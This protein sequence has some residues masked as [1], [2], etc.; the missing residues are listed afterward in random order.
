M[1]VE[2]KAAGPSSS[3][4]DA[5]ATRIPPRLIGLGAV[6]LI[7]GVFWM[8]R[9]SPK[10]QGPLPGFPSHADQFAQGDLANDPTFL[11][12]KQVAE[13]I[14]QT[15]H[16]LPGPELVDKFSWGMCVLPSMSSWVGVVPID[17]RNEPGGQYFTN[18]SPMPLQPMVNHSDWRAVVSYYLNAAPQNP[19]VPTNKAPVSLAFDGFKPEF[20]EYRLGKP[21]TT[22]VKIDALNRQFYICDAE[23]L[24][25]ALI[26][27]NGKLKASLDMTNP[28]VQ[29][30][31]YPSQSELT[32]TLIGNVYPSNERKGKLVTTPLPGSKLTAPKVL[33]SELQRPTDARFADLN[34]DGLV[35]IALCQFGNILGKYSWFE[36]KPDGTYVEHVLL[37][38]AGAIRSYVHDFNKDGKPDLIV[39][40]AQG[41]EGIYLFMNKGNGEFEQ[42]TVVEHVPSWGNSYFE[43]IDFNQ[44][45]FADILCTNGDNGDVP[46]YPNAPK[47][48]HGIRLLLNDGKNNFK[49]EWFYPMYG[50]YKA[51]LADFNGDGKPDICAI[52][53]FP[54]YL[55]KFKE[56]FVLL[57]NQ[58]GTNFKPFTFPE[59]I[60]GRWMTMDIGDIDGDGD[61]DIVL[62]AFNRS[63][64]DVPEILYG[65][66]EKRGPSM[67]ILR[68]TL[69]KK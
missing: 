55:G 38:R 47:A 11:R 50:A 66:W 7:L 4:E 39:M 9:P 13:Q 34:G 64:H 27:E 33:L 44:D 58:G 18:G 41:R 49:E 36:Q 25:L 62:G 46:D 57:M 67:V 42:Q 2:K 43:L 1:S 68:N 30:Q 69:R 35:D 32:L 3:G 56:S 20:P 21:M 29:L 45:G 6:L 31:N 60:S 5:E 65:E 26:G 51:R 61:T 8:L 10:T 48:Y 37:D 59:S 12:G 63:F 53:F 28:V 17:W 22:L 54:D 19:I 14:C 15:C 52:A 40:M 23:S 16:M 24:K